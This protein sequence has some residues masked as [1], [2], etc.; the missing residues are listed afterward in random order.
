MLASL[1]VHLAP[2]KI[3][4]HPLGSV[5]HIAVSRVSGLMEPVPG[6]VEVAAVSCHDAKVV[7]RR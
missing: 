3:E 4:K 6:L 5:C 7:Q 2:I 1:T